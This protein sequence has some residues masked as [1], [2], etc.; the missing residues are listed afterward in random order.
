MSSTLHVS[1]VC[2]ASNESE[3]RRTLTSLLKGCARALADENL[4]AVSVIL[5]DNGPSHS[6][7]DK[8]NALLQDCR[9]M[10]PDAMSFSVVGD[11]TNIG[12]GA[13]HNLA[14]NDE[15]CDFHLVLNPDV[16]LSENS[17]SVALQFMRNNPECG[18]LAPAVVNL[19]GECEFLCKRYPTLFDLFLRGFAPRWLKQKCEK[20]LAHYEMRDMPAD[21]I[22]WCP[23]IISG[24]FMLLRSS[25]LK[26]VGGFNPA[27]F[28]YFEDFDLSLRLA[29][30]SRIA[31]VP[32]VKIMHSGGHAAR[33]GWR[34]IWMFA[35]S[36]FTFFSHHGWKW[37]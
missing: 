33:K 1:V 30:V 3:L 12:F 18:V 24:C 19:T 4:T 5:V 7:R 26:Q 16:E 20:Q 13:G 29:S 21:L 34:H 27:Y 22:Y 10:S 23:P 35:R 11:G 14:F 37:Y 28:L 6:E 25:V 17:L 2:Y 15:T 31:Y 8:I 32:T 9:S 36:A